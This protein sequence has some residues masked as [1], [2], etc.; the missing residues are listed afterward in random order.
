M[1]G[2]YTQYLGE[3]GARVAHTEEDRAPGNALDRGVLGRGGLIALVS[4][5][6]SSTWQRMLGRGVLTL[7]AKRC[8]QRKI[9]LAVKIFIIDALL[10]RCTTEI[11][12]VRTQ[13]IC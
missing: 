5:K 8:S 12:L 4:W 3:R 1:S 7:L 9:W 11:M 13:G 10:T 6:K 2:V